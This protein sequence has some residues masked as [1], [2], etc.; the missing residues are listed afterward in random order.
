LEVALQLLEKT[1][2]EKPVKPYQPQVI[3]ALK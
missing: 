2:K 1:L 3:P